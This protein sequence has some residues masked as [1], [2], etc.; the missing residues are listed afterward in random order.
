[1]GNKED[2]KE[3]ENYDDGDRDRERGFD[4]GMNDGDRL[5]NEQRNPTMDRDTIKE[6]L[7]DVNEGKDNL[8]G[9]EKVGRGEEKG[10]RRLGTVD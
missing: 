8:N 10:K 5:L 6:A 3:R 9:E 4:D 1:M 2:M 7:G